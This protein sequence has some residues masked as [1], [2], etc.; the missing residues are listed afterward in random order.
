M[1]EQLEGLELYSAVLD[2]LDLEEIP[3]DPIDNALPNYTEDLNACFRDL[4]PKIGDGFLLERMSDKVW[5]CTFG[6]IYQGKAISAKGDNP[7]TAICRAFLK[8]NK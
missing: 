3:Y 4:V 8:V 2:K 6:D 7:A 1:I 5:L